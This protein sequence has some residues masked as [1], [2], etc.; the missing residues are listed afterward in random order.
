MFPD[1]GYKHH[2]VAVKEARLKIASYPEVHYKDGKIV[3]IS[4]EA[5]DYMIRTID[6][7][8]KTLE[9]TVIDGDETKTFNPNDRSL[10]SYK[11]DG[12][13]MRKF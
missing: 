1:C 9:M 6:A 3:T 13:S 12:R 5:G 8:G 2:I 10:T 4:H 11:E 7:K